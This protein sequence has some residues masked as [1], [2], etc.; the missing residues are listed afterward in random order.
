ME[1]NGP[2]Q[3]IPERVDPQLT[4]YTVQDLKPFTP[5]RF[6]IQ[7]TNDIGPSSFSAESVEVRTRPAAPSRG[8]TGVKVVPITTTSVEVY[9]DIIE[10]Q[11]W[12]GDMSTGG[13]RVIFQPVSDYPTALQATP[14]EEIKGSRVSSLKKRK[15][16]ERK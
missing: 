6:R 8:V 13:Y 14:K 5:Y 16:K 4:S 3:L 7:A 11:F 9:W 1:S 15:Y 10:E 2:W 12:S